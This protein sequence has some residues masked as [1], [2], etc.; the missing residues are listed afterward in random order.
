MKSREGG[1]RGGGGKVKIGMK[2]LFT[3]QFLGCHRAELGRKWGAL[4]PRGE[5]YN[6]DNDC[7]NIP[8]AESEILILCDKFDKFSS[9][10]SC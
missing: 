5:K 10:K 6:N 7:N 4:G 1:G 8:N 3:G 9:R 2:Y